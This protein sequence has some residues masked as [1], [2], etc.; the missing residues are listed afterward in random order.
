M[1]AE[2]F[3]DSGLPRPHLPLLDITLANEKKARALERPDDN[4][5][6]I[7]IFTNESH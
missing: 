2:D 6:I 3:E 7:R 4:K 5:Y 1:A